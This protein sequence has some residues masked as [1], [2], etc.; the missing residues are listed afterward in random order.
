MSSQKKTE[1]RT[2][3]KKVIIRLFK[4]IASLEPGFV[5]LLN[6]KDLDLHGYS[7][8]LKRKSVEQR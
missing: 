3:N 4:R 8:N 2:Q 5:L 7:T 1:R 6:S